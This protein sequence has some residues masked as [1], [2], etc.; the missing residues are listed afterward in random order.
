MEGRLNQQQVDEIRSG[1]RVDDFFFD[2][3]D[4][5]TRDYT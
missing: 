2:F 3:A 1:L 5:G 4:R